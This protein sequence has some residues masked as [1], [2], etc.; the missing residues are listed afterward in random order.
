MTCTHHSSTA[1]TILFI[2]DQHVTCYRALY[3]QDFGLLSLVASL[4]TTCN[5]QFGPLYKPNMAIFS[6]LWQPYHRWCGHLLQFFVPHLVYTTLTISITSRH[7][8]RQCHHA[9]GLP[10]IWSLLCNI[11]LLFPCPP[12]SSALPPLVPFLVMHSLLLFFFQ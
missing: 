11:Q 4:T 10:H 1:Y 9:S 12:F 2:T 7:S 8:H 6:C 3:C 5:R